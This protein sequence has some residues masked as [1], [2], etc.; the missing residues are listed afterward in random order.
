M[1]DAYSFHASLDDLRAYYEEWI[2][3]YQRVFARVGLED[4]APVPSDEG[5]MGG[6]ISH[7]FVLLSDAGED[8]VA[9]CDTCSYGA[10]LDVAK[11]RVESYEEA[12]LPLEKV[13]TPGTKSIDALAGFLDV[14]PSRTAKVCFYDRDKDGKLVVVLIRGDL[15]VNEVGLARLIQIHPAPASEERIRGAGAVP[16][17]ATPI[18]LDHAACR[19]LVDESVATSNN[20]VCG[21]NEVDHHLKNFNLA[22]DLPNANTH[23]LAKV[24]DLDRCPICD[25]LLHVR[26]GIQLGSVFQLGKKYTSAMQMTFTD[27]TGA[28]RVPAMGCYG[29]GIGRLVSSIMEVHHDE[30]G[31]KWPISVAPWQVHLCAIKREAPGVRGAADALYA[32]LEER[33]VEV[34][35]DDR[36]LRAGVQFAEADLLGAPFRVTVGERH[37]K[38]GEV[39]WKRRDTDEAGRLPLDE[40]VETVSGWVAEALKQAKAVDDPWGPWD[41][42]GRGRARYSADT[43]TLISRE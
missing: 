27:E 37:L 28:T 23:N 31:P 5:I 33:G 43:G 32:G 18:G 20:L 21:A 38:N 22:R 17:F 4:V 14:E 39:E 2:K 3:V 24:R 36:D 13:H 34:I 40:A 29:I 1:N 30:H 19:I 6:L 10:G 16:G 25:G 26:R 8:Q 41:T 15:E 35:Y 9:L 12:P 42:R 7:E 11:G